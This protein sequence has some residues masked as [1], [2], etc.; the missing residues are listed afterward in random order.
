MSMLETKH[1]SR[2]GATRSGGQTRARS[3][4]FSPVLIRSLYSMAFVCALAVAVY[5]AYKVLPYINPEIEQVVVS[6][7]MKRLDQSTLSKAVYENL[8]GGLLTLDI[9]YLRSEI[10]KIAWVESVELV[11][12]FPSTLAVHIVEEQAIAGWNDQGY[13]SNTGEFID[14]VLYEDLSDLP[15]LSSSLKG[16]DPQLGAKKSIEIFHMLNSTALMY[17]QLVQE[18]RQSASG[19]WTMIWD[20]GLSVDLG[21]VDH[22]NRTRHAMAAWQRLPED[23]KSNID[24]IDARYDNGVAIR[25]RS[26]LSMTSNSNVI[27]NLTL[28]LT[29]NLTRLKPGTE[30]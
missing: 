7:D 4:T 24:R 13:I 26:G 15:L 27:S 2:Q 21:R 18:L 3:M 6:G 9:E 17:G 12:H 16:I 5:G 8:R 29:P 20:N 22:L 10:S 14:S 1:K 11:K 23:V 28:K 25:S 19:G 30:A